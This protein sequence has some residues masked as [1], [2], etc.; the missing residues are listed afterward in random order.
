MIYLFFNYKNM[1]KS[2]I[3]L[4]IK[5][6]RFDIINGDL[7]CRVTW[8][9]SPIRSNVTLSLQPRAT[10]LLQRDIG[11]VALHTGH[12]HEHQQQQESKEKGHPHPIFIILITDVL[13]YN[14][15]IKN[16]HCA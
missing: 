16:S 2:L 13:V 8:P 7:A 3:W 9:M 6:L 1:K 15:S 11:H 4:P 12:H 10:L 5:D 14:S